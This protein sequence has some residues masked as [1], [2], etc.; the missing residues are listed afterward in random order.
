MEVI[1]SG[2][3]YDKIACMTS[4]K[5]RIV[6]MGSPAFS[7]PILQ[8]LADCDLFE[9]VGVVTQP[10]RPKGRGRKLVSPPVKE[11]AMCHSEHLLVISGLTHHNFRYKQV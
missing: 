11:L 8:G 4:K 2:A 5:Y 6:F 1:P 10:D 7:L 3:G 9:I